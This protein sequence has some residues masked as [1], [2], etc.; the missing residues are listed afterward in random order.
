MLATAIGN[1]DDLTTA[2]RLGAALLFVALV[3]F[4]ALLLYARSTGLLR[5]DV[6]PDALT[7]YMRTAV[8]VAPLV[9][10]LAF[11]RGRMARGPGWRCWSG[12]IC[13]GC[14]HWSRTSRPPASSAV[15]DQPAAGR[16]DGYDADQH[17]EVD[18]AG[19]R[20]PPAH[21]AEPEQGDQ[22]QHAE[23]GVRD[24]AGGEPARGPARSAV[25]TAATPN[26]I[27]Q[28]ETARAVSGVSGHGHSVRAVDGAT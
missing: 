7:L 8:F 9:P 16:P 18:D 21:V 24:G 17:D 2:V 19:R 14:F 10:V 23:D 12:S 3:A 15:R 13:W 1:H 25:S 6:Q 11:V 28:A 26:A 22:L 5:D 27:S 4:A 20:V